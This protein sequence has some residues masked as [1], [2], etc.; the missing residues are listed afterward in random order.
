VDDKTFAEYVDEIK[1]YLPREEGESN[2][3]YRARV[4]FTAQNLRQ[5]EVSPWYR[6]SHE[7][8]LHTMSVRDELTHPKQRLLIKHKEKYTRWA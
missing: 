7:L 1:Q 6:P 2:V 8:E 5:K 4:Y 3:D